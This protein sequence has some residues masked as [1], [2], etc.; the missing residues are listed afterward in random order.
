[1]ISARE[2]APIRR[3]TMK[4]LAAD[5][6]P[7]KNVFIK[8]CDG[9]QLHCISFRAYRNNEYYVDLGI[10]FSF[11]PS[12]KIYGNDHKA[13]HPE[14]ETCAFHARW[15]LEGVSSVYPYGDTLELSSH[16]FV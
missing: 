1:M 14:P 8:H 3:R 4:S 16:S 10:H 2:F 7:R 12:F 5:F 11:M 9:Q 15:M 6:E 13:A